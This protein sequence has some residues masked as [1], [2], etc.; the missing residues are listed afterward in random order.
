MSRT[1]ALTPEERRAFPKGPPAGAPAFVPTHHRIPNPMNS[2]TYTVPELSQ[3]TH[4]P[5]V[6]HQQARALLVAASALVQKGWCRRHRALSVQGRPVAPQADEAAYWSLVGSLI[7][8]RERNT[9]TIHPEAI[10]V[11][12]M[13]IY[14]TLHQNTPKHRPVVLRR[15]WLQ[16][17]SPRLRRGD[18]PPQPSPQRLR[19]ALGRR[20]PLLPTG[21]AQGRR[22]GPALY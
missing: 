16:R 5:D 2:P 20:H 18:R 22:V 15:R 10:W 11:A 14:H 21:V 8:H 3:F 17:P 4:W 9:H 13:A 19:R 7:A 6:I 12:L 1:R